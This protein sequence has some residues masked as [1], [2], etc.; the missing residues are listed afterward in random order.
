MFS[1]LVAMTLYLALA[2]SRAGLSIADFQPAAASA[3]ELPKSSLP[4]S[5]P[6]AEDR[7]TVRG[8]FKKDLARLGI[9]T[10]S[11]SIAVIDWSTGVPLFEKNADKPQAIA[12]ITKLMT[13]L[14]VLSTDPDWDKVVSVGASDELPGGVAY[15]APGEKVKVRDLL[16]MSLIASS[17]G[18]TMALA[19]S[20]GL[21]DQE[22]A[23]KMNELAQGFGMRHSH[24]D[25]PTGLD[26][27]NVASARDVAILLKQALSSE[28]IQDIVTK[29]VYEFVS[30]SARPH[31]IATTD[32]L[33]D[34]FLSK[35]PY[36]FLG[37]K[38]GYI[39]EAGYCFSAAV[40]NA[41]GDS[42]I[43]VALGAPTRDDRFTDVKRSIFWAFDAFEW[44]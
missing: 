17:N 3:A 11:R 35:P 34:S 19:R 36:V 30:E 39:D 10:S 22:F 5:G 37:G 33:L 38:T 32:M 26:S 31:K 1:L 14:V 29:K 2:P 8:P 44:R 16:H 12:S 24:F 23:A 28:I 20:T 18:A 40:R 25:E 13:A 42:V 15:L 21:T 41:T 9:E 4:L 7:L 43:A 27:G 6:A